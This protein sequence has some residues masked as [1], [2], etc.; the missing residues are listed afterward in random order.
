MQYTFTNRQLSKEDPESDSPFT[1]IGAGHLR[2]YGGLLWASSRGWAPWRFATDGNGTIIGVG[3]PEESSGLTYNNH[4]VKRL[5][6][7]Q[8]VDIDI[9]TGRFNDVTYDG[10]FHVFGTSTGSDALVWTSN[11]SGETWTS[12]GFIGMTIDAGVQHPRLIASDGTGNLVVTGTITVSEV[13][14]TTIRPQI[15]V[16]SSSWANKTN[17]TTGESGKLSSYEDLLFADGKFVSVGRWNGGKKGFSRTSSDGGSTWE[18]S[19]FDDYSMGSVTYGTFGGVGYFFAGGVTDFS[20]PS[21][22]GVSAVFVSSDGVTW[23]TLESMEEGQTLGSVRYG[24]ERLVAGGRGPLTGSYD[25]SVW[26]YGNALSVDSSILEGRL[27][28]SPTPGG[29]WRIG[30]IGLG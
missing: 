2:L 3:P 11:D 6:G 9:G 21:L 24:Q 16:K 13:F 4:V 14:G 18:L 17:Y 29:G 1:I 30:K 15:F 10:A 20:Y 23:D 19:F 8:W 27:T 5:Q 26:S 22:L 28:Y 12:S 25:G 7:N